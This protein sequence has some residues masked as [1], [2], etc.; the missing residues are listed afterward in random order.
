MRR[1]LSL[2]LSVFIA[3]TALAFDFT[4]KTFQG[5]T[6]IDGA[7]VTITY[8]FKANNRMSG[9][10]SMQGQKSESDHGMHWEIAGDYMNIYDSLGDMTYM[11]ISESEDGKPV[12]IAFD[13]YGRE[14]MVFKQVT[15]TP[16]SKSKTGT[17]KKKR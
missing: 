2:F 9:T 12:L 5:S 16:A 1:M 7:K 10:L 13:S 8:R 17:S 3:V 11:E 15:C 6:V 4:G 14:A